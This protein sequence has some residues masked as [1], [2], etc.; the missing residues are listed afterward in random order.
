MDLWRD[1]PEDSTD[2]TDGGN[3]GSDGNG[4]GDDNDDDDDDYDNGNGSYN[5]DSD[6][7]DGNNRG[8]Y[9]DFDAS[10][11]DLDQRESDSG[12]R[13]QF[14]NTAQR[15]CE[16]RRFARRNPSR[17]D[18]RRIEHQHNARS[19]PSSPDERLVKKRKVEER[20]PQRE[21]G[22]KRNETATAI[23]TNIR[24]VASD[25]TE[26][27]VLSEFRRRLKDEWT[28]KS[29]SGRPFIHVQQLQ[30]WMRNRP[31]VNSSINYARLL[32]VAYLKPNRRRMDR[33]S[34]KIMYGAPSMPL[35]FAILL[36]LDQG[37]LIYLFSEAGVDDRSLPLGP[38]KHSSLRGVFELH[39]IPDWQPLLRRFEE[40]QWSYCPAVLGGTLCEE[41]SEETALDANIILPFVRQEAVNEKVGTARVYRVS[42]PEDFVSYPLR[43]DA[44]QEENCG[45]FK[46][47]V[48]LTNSSSLLCGI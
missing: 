19:L 44:V 16:Q 28:R 2:A 45:R 37:H 1:W 6:V 12:K 32:A 18:T 46:E 36:Q 29:S 8:N 24:V 3:G 48:C 7:A 31:T 41:I 22:K 42:V 27:E 13:S 35:V 26:S 33:P 10:R 14:N 4:G 23:Q 5:K 30:A 25:F 15:N 11:R 47:P 34:D 40:L 39:H 21:Q 17:T 9:R 38:D 43:E 20:S